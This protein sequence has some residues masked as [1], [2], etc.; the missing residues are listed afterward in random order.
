[1]YINYEGNRAALYDSLI[2]KTINLND[3]DFKECIKWEE[4]KSVRNILY[5][6]NS[7]WINGKFRIDDNYK[8]IVIDSYHAELFSFDQF[9][10]ENTNKKLNNWIT[11]KTKGK[12]T[13]IAG[14]HKDIMLSLINAVYFM[15]E[16]NSPFDTKKTKNKNF[17]TI[18]KTKI[19]V[20]YMRGRRYYNYYEDDNF[21]SVILP[22]KCHQFSM[23]VILP[24]ERYGILDIEKKL[25]LNYLKAI[26][27][28]AS[29]NE[30]I[31]SLPKF[32]IETEIFLKEVIIRMNYPG[33]FS[34]KADFTGM[35]E[36]DSLKIGDIIHKTY[37]D[38]NEK[39]TEAA[40]VSRADMVVI[41]YGGGANSP[42]PPPPKIFNANHPFTFLIIDNRTNAILFAGRFAKGV[43]E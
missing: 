4:D 12:I 11:E 28:K 32:K 1:L 17:Y 18:D 40:A 39:N 22:Y 43:N 36:T 2:R 10:I 23:I 33:M 8:K 38:V 41:G 20:D 25:S 24:R 34:D 42:P 19:K 13:E 3:T 6:A 37:I 30:V 21:Q 35:S 31:L 16:W 29:M 5:L 14:V 26:N 15:G 7:L 27:Q 9:N